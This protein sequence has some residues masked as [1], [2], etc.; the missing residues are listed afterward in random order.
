MLLEEVQRPPV[1]AHD[2]AN[3]TVV[4]RITRSDGVDVDLGLSEGVQNAR[5]RA[6]PVV[7]ED[8]QLFCDLHKYNTSLALRVPRLFHVTT[9]L[10]SIHNRQSEIGPIQKARFTTPRMPEMVVLDI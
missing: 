1:V 4:H 6:G 5:Q 9:I 7:Q 2:Q 3:D 10:D 8:C